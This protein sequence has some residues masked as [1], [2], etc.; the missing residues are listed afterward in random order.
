MKFP[1][2]REDAIVAHT[3]NNAVM[4]IVGWRVMYDAATEAS[5]R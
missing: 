1:I 4:T 5:T 2:S 3:R